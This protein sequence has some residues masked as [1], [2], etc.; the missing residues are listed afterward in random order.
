M[1][2]KWIRAGIL[3]T[4]AG[5]GGLAHA[6]LVS[7]LGTITPNGTVAFSNS[8]VTTGTVAPPSY[9]FLDRWSFTLGANASVSSI[10]ATIYFTATP[11]GPP[12]FGI[13]NLQINLVTDPVSGA[14]LVSWQSV[15]NPA[16][17]L[18]ETIALIPSSALGAGNYVLQVRGT[19]TAPGSYSGSLIAA[20]A[21]VPL[22]AAF[23][24]LLSG[25][26]ALGG[27]GLKRRRRDPV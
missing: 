4:L 5:S 13:S 26:G 17:N 27:M 2:V 24:L 14:P 6:D 18:T 22:P 19:V 16:P 11:D 23:P 3:A 21:A 15:T 25:L 1:N 8:N 12:V 9:N 7:S 20:P 10:A